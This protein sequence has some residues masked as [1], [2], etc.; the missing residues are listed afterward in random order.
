MHTLH[1][2]AGLLLDLDMLLRK[3]ACDFTLVLQLLAQPSTQ[4]GATH[5]HGLDC[6]L[7]ENSAL[8]AV[9][10]ASPYETKGWGCGLRTVSA[11]WRGR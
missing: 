11:Y 1:S 2:C 8:K 6:T 4:R 3:L 9:L 5:S 7:R 10:S